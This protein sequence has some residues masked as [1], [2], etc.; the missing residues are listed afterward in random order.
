LHQQ[1]EDFALAVHSPPQPMGLCQR[2]IGLV[3]SHRVV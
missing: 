3:V 2:K 1:I